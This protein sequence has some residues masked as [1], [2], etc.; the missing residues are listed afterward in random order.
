MSIKELELDEQFVENMHTG[1]ADG[2]WARTVSTLPLLWA[3]PLSLSEHKAQDLIQ[4]RSRGAYPL[5]ASA[6]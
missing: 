6:F 3:L 1:I 4:K 2:H 5:L